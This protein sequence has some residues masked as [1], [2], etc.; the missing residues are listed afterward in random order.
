MDGPY[1]AGS[2]N[3]HATVYRHTERDSPKGTLVAVATGCQTCGGGVTGQQ[4]AD[5][6]NAQ[7]RK[8]PAE[9][10][11]GELIERSS[12]NAG[13]AASYRARATAEDYA[14]ANAVLARVDELDAHLSDTDGDLI[15][16]IAMAAAVLSQLPREEQRARIRA[17]YQDVDLQQERTS[18]RIVLTEELLDRIVR[19]A[20]RGYELHQIRD[21]TDRK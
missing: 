16:V 3:P 6:L 18:G 8:D 17:A 15:Y 20:E 7:L 2:K 1:R 13:A 10:G 11:T 19:E 4:I 21:R 9:M 14:D 5:A 12:V